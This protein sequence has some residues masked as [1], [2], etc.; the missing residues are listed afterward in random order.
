MKPIQV[1]MMKRRPSVPWTPAA[2]PNQKV[3]FVS[4]NPD[5]TLS[6]AYLQALADKGG[7]LAAQAISSGNYADLSQKLG[8]RTV[9]TAQSGRI[10]SFVMANA[11]RSLLTDQAGVTGYIVTKMT[12][13]AAHGDNPL[14]HLSINPSISS[15]FTMSR[16]ESADGTFNIGTRRLDTDAYVGRATATNYGTNWI[17]G[18]ARLDYNIGIATMR[19]NGSDD[20]SGTLTWAGGYGNTS[21][22]I[23][24]TACIGTYDGNN[25]GWFEHSDAEIVLCRGALTLADMQRMEGYLAW[26][27]GLADSLPVGHPYKA[28]P[29]LV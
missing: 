7:G 24:N 23:S 27:W 6:G 20:N 22:T 19:V 29:P 11:A 21:N 17:I 13:P 14:V 3:W 28:A 4:D 25:G 2:L 1:M 16:A 10:A 12:S 5:N 9:W 8:G 15:R 18:G 26:Q